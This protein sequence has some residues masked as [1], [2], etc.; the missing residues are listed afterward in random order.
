MKIKKRSD[1]KA[2]LVLIDNE[3]KLNYY[4]HE[5]PEI[6]YDLI[7]VSDRPLTIIYPGARKCCSQSYWQRWKHWASGVTRETVFQK[8]CVNVRENLLSP[9]R[10]ISVERTSPRFFSEISEEIK[11]SVDYIVHFRQEDQTEGLSFTDNQIGNRW[12]N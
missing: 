6:A 3:V 4:M 2:M 5:V 11:K 10:P 9:H 12:T 1:S 8:H 7:E